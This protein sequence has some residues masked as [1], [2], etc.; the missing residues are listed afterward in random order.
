MNAAIVRPTMLLAGAVLAIAAALLP[1]RSDATAQVADRIVIDGAEEQLLSNPLDA[2]LASL[3]PL[4][5]Q[6]V[7]PHTALWRGYVAEWALEGDALYLT[8]LTGHLESGEITLADLFPGQA[9]VPAT[10]FSGRLRV[11]MGGLVHYE[12][13]GYAS[14]YETELFLTVQQ[15]RV[16]ERR[17]VVNQ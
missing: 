16:I 13:M 6:F 7:A 10:W 12:H 8:G 3:G 17:L 1:T 2:Y 4:R 15:G 5:P 14:V 11:G 9:R